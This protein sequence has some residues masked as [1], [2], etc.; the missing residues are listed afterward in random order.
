MDKPLA[1]PTSAADRFCEKGR[2]TRRPRK[3][4][5]RECAP[6]RQCHVQQSQ[7]N[8]SLCETDFHDFH[9]NNLTSCVN[10]YN[11]WPSVAVA[12]SLGGSSHLHSAYFQHLPRHAGQLRHLSYHCCAR[13]ETK[14]TR[15][16]R[17]AGKISVKLRAEE[18][19]MRR[20]ERAIFGG[21][22]NG[23]DGGG[24]LLTVPFRF[25]NRPIYQSTADRRQLS[26]QRR[27]SGG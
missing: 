6:W 18:R 17:W 24:I 22:D 27:I 23:D 21:S 4:G 2:Q 8:S 20:K 11:M 26:Q 16:S 7:N 1:P 3:G 14:P 5:G 9:R 13:C 19:T 15:N 12:F 10:D 25:L